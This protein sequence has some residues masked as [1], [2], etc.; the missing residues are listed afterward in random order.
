S[1]STN[2]II[3]ASRTLRLLSLTIGC[4]DI[5]VEHEI[6]EDSIPRISQALKLDSDPS[7]L[8]CE[9][10]SERNNQVL[11]A[12]ISAWSFLLASLNSW[13]TSPKLWNESIPY[14]FNLLDESDPSMG[15]V[16]GETLALIIEIG[17]IE[18]FSND[19]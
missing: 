16:A 12:A 3:L 13:S 2:E 7:S 17:A 8:L 9:A 14:L 1:K 18:K 10:T 19:Y 6:L 4:Q 11:I 5:R 15:M